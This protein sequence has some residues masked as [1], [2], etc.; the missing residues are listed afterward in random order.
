MIPNQFWIHKNHKVAFEAIK[1]LRDRHLD[2]YLVCTGH[3]S[4]VR[5][6]GNFQ[7]LCDYIK[8]HN[9]ENRIRILGFIPR[10]EQL[11]IMRG[12]M[13]IVQPSLFEGW[14][15]VVE[16]ARALG[17]PLFLSDLPVHREQDP[18]GAV[19]F[20]PNNSEM[21]ADEL[22]KGWDAL[23]PGPSRVREEAALA[24]QEELIAQYARTFL[25]IVQELLQM[26]RRV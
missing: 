2:P 20:D 3:T 25:H 22:A 8:D 19:Y 18:P 14:S 24:D 10:Q 16:D 12:A 23:C 7:L 15:T 17:I 4:D 11:H 26:G 6:P 9:L 21:L 1:I 13:A 5:Q